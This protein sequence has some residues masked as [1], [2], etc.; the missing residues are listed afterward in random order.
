MPEKI[1]TLADGFKWLSECPAVCEE[2]VRWVTTGML[3]GLYLSGASDLVLEQIQKY[4]DMP[5]HLRDQIDRCKLDCD[6]KVRSLNEEIG[7][8]VTMLENKDDEGE[9]SDD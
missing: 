4:S 8:W 7:R 6:R 3:S 9:S 2:F 5:N 1:D